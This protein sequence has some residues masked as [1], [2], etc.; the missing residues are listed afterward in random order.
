MMALPRPETEALPTLPDGI[1]LWCARAG[2]AV[3]DDAGH[4]RGDRTAGRRT[5]DGLN[6]TA[7]QSRNGR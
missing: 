5:T 4:G 6:S 1:T 3:R 7:G 2:P